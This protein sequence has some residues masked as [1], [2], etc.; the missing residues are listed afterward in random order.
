MKKATMAQTQEKTDN[1]EQQN[2][3]TSKIKDNP[4]VQNRK[5]KDQGGK[6][7]TRQQMQHHAAKDLKNTSIKEQQKHFRSKERVEGKK[8]DFTFHNSKGY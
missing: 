6:K 8:K 2:I 7:N 1:I 3:K 5:I 4:T